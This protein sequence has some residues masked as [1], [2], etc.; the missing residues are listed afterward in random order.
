[1][2][3]VV[4]K[5]D[6]LLENVKASSNLDDYTIFIIGVAPKEKGSSHWIFAPVQAMSLAFENG[7]NPAAKALCYSAS[8]PIIGPN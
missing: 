7:D 5:A 6:Y 2:V 8:G 1:M 4:R 3:A